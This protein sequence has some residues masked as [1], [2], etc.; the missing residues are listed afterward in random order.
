MRHS[1]SPS[2]S[3]DLHTWQVGA[4]VSVVGCH[5]CARAFEDG[6]VVVH[7]WD[8]LPAVPGLM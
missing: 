2:S 6:S 4:E 3:E 5:V 1:P 8:P 7:V